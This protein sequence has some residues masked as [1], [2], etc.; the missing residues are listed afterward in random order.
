MSLQCEFLEHHSEIFNHYYLCHYRPQAHGLDELSKSLL[1]FKRGWPL[2]V[3]AWTECS[4]SELCKIGINKGCLILRALNSNEIAVD[5]PNSPLD[6][7]GRKI[8]S[9][10]KG[11]YIPECLVKRRRVRKLSLLS[12]TER[13]LEL[14]DN[15][16]FDG[17]RAKRYYSEILI[18]DDILTSGTTLRS[19]IDAIRLAFPTCLVQ[20]FTLAS[21]DKQARLNQSIHLSS[22]GYEWKSEKGWL[23]VE[24][25]PADYSQIGRLKS[26]ILTDSFDQ[27]H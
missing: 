26:K 10:L 14:S 21:T 4:I 3:A 1:N 2:D 20:S 23:I 18:L 13:E 6:D 24:D 15:Y 16:V 5:K 12:R 27:N 9:A 17:T 22:I 11:D 19:I 8:A 7:L 25:K